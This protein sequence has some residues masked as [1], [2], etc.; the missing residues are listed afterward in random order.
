MTESEER[1]PGFA[2][3]AGRLARTGVG[4]LRNRL[5][6]FAVEWQEERAR[7]TEL[8]LWLVGL[9]FLGILGVLML[10]VTIVLL[11]PP[12]FRLYVA[13]GFALLYL[14]GA[15]IAWAVVKSLLKHEPFTETIDQAKKDAAWLDS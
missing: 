15:G 12:Q 11:F 4:A 9:L 7:L 14:I 1:E 5:E 8:I 2:T 6:L 3:L 13:G 10:T